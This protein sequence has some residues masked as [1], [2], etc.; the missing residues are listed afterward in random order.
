M[1]LHY[2]VFKKAVPESQSCS[3]HLSLSLCLSVLSCPRFKLG[4]S[5][6]SRAGFSDMEV[7]DGYVLWWWGGRSAR[8][9]DRIV[10][11]AELGL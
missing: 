11:V 6:V 8:A 9:C 10:F 3:L 1:K 4:L 7:M 5:S 2:Y